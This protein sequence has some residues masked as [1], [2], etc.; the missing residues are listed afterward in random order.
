MTLAGKRDASRA[1][2]ATDFLHRSG[3]RREHDMELRSALEIAQNFEENCDT[4]A[5]IITNLTRDR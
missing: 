5:V 2:F 3:Q 1:V 4:N